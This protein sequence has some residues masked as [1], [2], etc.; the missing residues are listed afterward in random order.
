MSNFVDGMEIKL[1][2]L[3]DPDGNPIN[4][5]SASRLNDELASRF[6]R[7]CLLFIFRFKVCY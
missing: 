3:S 2:G 7:G 6:I 4:A 1:S 5:I